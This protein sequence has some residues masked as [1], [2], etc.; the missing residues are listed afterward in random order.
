M[1]VLVVGLF[2]CYFVIFKLYSVDIGFIIWMG[3]MF[4]KLGFLVNDCFG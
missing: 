3:F 2:G 1:F 4:L